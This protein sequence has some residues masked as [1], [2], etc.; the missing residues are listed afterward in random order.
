MKK[1]MLLCTVLALATACIYPYHPDLEEAPQG[2]LVV[3]GSLMLGEP[4]MVQIG[5]MSSLWTDKNDSAP[6]PG[7]YLYSTGQPDMAI[8]VWA[9]DS[10]GDIYEGKIAE[11]G[12]GHL[13]V[14]YLLPTENA[15]ADREYR[16]CVQMDGAQYSSDW[17]KPLTPPVIKKINFRATLNDVQ[18]QVSVDGGPDA[19][20][21]LLLSFDETW[22]F[23]TEYFL[24]YDYDLRTN[25]VSEYRLTPWDRYWCFRTLDQGL[26]VPVDYSDL[27]I[28]GVNNYPLHS[29]SRYDDRNH[30]RYSIRVKARTIDKR[31]YDYLRHLEEST[32]AGDD[33]FTP[34]PGEV[35]GNIRCETDPNRRVLGY[36]TVST[37]S[38]RRAYLGS[39]YL[40][41]KTRNPYDLRYPLQNGNLIGENSWRDYYN[42]GYMPLIPNTLPNSD[43][44]EEGP[45]GWG[46][47][48]CYD[49]FAAGGT[50]DVPD[51]WEE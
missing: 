4:S 12:W 18:V 42:K 10:A 17:I 14:P 2:V 23:H 51:F 44:E 13:M 37:S 25:S 5:L 15:P 45:Y 6:S 7:G 40:L 21:Y 29:F 28:D 46:E 50:Q 26:Q 33:L 35:Q 39:Q 1:S 43:P 30:R 8:R 24:N 16:V 20:G 34:N 9:E 48:R 49:C 22:R 38:T 32:D 36:V 19:T 27:S 41:T 31:T 47:A 3:E 11:S